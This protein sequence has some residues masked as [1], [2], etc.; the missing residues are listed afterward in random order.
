MEKPD[1]ISFTQSLIRQ[2]STSSCE[3]G[4]VEKVMQEMHALNYDQV[5]VDVNGSAVGIIE[6]SLPGPTLL[7]DAHCDVV[8]AIPSDWSHDP[9]AAQIVGDMMYGR[10]TADTKG[11]LA[12]MLYAAA[13]VDRSK[14]AGKVAVSATVDEELMEGPTLKTVMETVHPDY[15]VIG[16]ATD[17]NLNRG[18]RGRAELVI[19]TVGRS[20]HSSSPQ[21]GLCAI[22]EMIKVIRAVE[23]VDVEFDPLLGPGFIVLTDI[24]SEPYPGHSV[25]ANRCRVSYDRRLLV[26]ETMDSVVNRINQLPELNGVEYSTK[27]LFAEHQTYTGA[28]L[29]GWKFYPAWKLEENH[30]FVQGALNGLHSARLLPEVG[31]YRFC[32]NAAYSAGTAGIPTVGFGLGKES[33]AH[34]VDERI[35]LADLE[36]AE[37]GYKGIIESILVK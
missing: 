25:I 3:Q 2:R 21:V 10:G 29:R 8:D 7:L 13:S 20:A 19:E 17:F 1:L 33:D 31:A 27:V 6:G 12:A 28:T 36:Q 18:G 37:R 26:G 4:V 35:H 14:L 9:F 32:T 15:V 34:T 11:N 16:E 30:P 24:I 22:H 23:E 5:W